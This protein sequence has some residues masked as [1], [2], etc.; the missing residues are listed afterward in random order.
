MSRPE[1]AEH[2]EYFGNYVALV[3]EGDVLAAL[4]SELVR[5]LELLRV[6][7]EEDAGRCHPPYTWTVRQ[8][9]GHLIDTER[10]FA[11]RALRFAR[12]DSTPLAGF[13]EN[14]YVSAGAFDRLPL[15]A[16]ASEFE[17]VRQATLRLFE[18]LPEPAWDQRGIANN[19]AVSLR[20]LA[21]IIVGH[22][23]HHAAILRKRLTK[24]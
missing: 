3:P 4:R 14:E 24:D 6:V 9:V 16:L 18:N 23:R 5:T 15:G 12:E 19:A 17:A 8:V 21:Y 20:A 11:Y 22:E 13:E 7:P 10:I 1:P 2:A